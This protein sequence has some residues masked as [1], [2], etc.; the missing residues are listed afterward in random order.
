MR[1]WIFIVTALIGC[2]TPYQPKGILGGYEDY[3]VKGSPGLHFVSFEGTTATDDDVVYRHWRQRAA[4][5]CAG[6]D[7]Q[8]VSSGDRRGI[9]PIR[10]PRVEGFVRCGPPAEP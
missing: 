7:L 8:I 9:V 4:E 1:R 2:A 6:K 5:I 3:E 10:R